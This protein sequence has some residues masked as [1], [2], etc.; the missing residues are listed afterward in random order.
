MSQT[1]V[2]GLIVLVPYEW[3]QEFY[4]E[5]PAYL[6]VHVA[7]QDETLALMAVAYETCVNYRY[8]TF[9]SVW[10][11]EQSWQTRQYPGTLQEPGIELPAA[12]EAYEIPEPGDCFCCASLEEYEVLSPDEMIERLQSAPE[13]FILAE[14]IHSNEYDNLWQQFNQWA[15]QYLEVSIVEDDASVPVLEAIGFVKSR[16]NQTSEWIDAIV[17]CLHEDAETDI[18]SELDALQQDGKALQQQLEQWLDRVSAYAIEHAD[19]SNREV[20]IKDQ[21][22]EGTMTMAETIE[23]LKDGILRAL[24][25]G[26]TFTDIA[27]MLTGQGIEIDAF[28]LSYYL[29]K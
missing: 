18:P 16:L 20:V 27:E 14:M 10:E 29:S 23:S 25:L 6:P 2:D 11:T 9:S 1:S 13:D 8:V 4:G 26:Y 17:Q 12:V 15:E 22:E 3:G 28:T 19:F 24:D 5:D 21:D 7:T